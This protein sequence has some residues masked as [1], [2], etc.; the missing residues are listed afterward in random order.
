MTSYSSWLKQ[1]IKF[2]L[3]GLSNT[4]VD[5][6]VYFILTRYF[7]IS[8]VPAAAGAFIV[9]VSWSF[10]INR[11]WTFKQLTGSI[12]QQYWRFAVVG[13][14]SFIIS[15]TAFVGLVDGLGVYDLVAKVLVALISAII[16][17]I[18]SR[19]WVFGVK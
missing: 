11:Q 17:F 1:F 12:V 6:A 18:L 8:Y 7:L 5:F 4:A 9:A 19:I 14:I 16:G 10:I 15:L 2:C 3:V 13:I